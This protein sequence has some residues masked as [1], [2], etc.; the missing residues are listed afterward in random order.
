MRVV[1]LGPPGVGKGTQASIFC[2]NNDFRHIS[3][4]ELLRNALE[5]DGEMGQKIRKFM[6]AGDLVPDDLM[7]GMIESALVDEQNGVVFDGFPRTE[8]QARGLDDLLEKRNERVDRVVLLIA[9]EAE[10]IRRV[11]ARGRSDDTLETVRHRFEVYDAS[12]APLI[13]YYRERGTLREVDGMGAISE[14][15]ERI[16]NALM[17]DGSASGRSAG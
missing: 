11:L 4:G 6:E 17:D 16:H 15:Q 7:L 2:R 13:E 10:V 5:L 3:T 14:I 8:V 12:T 1:F 9:D